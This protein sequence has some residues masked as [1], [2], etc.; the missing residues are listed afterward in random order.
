MHFRLTPRTMTLDDVEVLQGQ[1][2][3]EFRKISQIWEPT[4]AK[5]MKIDPYCQRMNVNPY[6][7]GQRGNLLN[8]LFKIMFLAFF[9]AHFL[10]HTCTAVDCCHALTL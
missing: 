8:V 9:A 10:F 4:T 1:I 3:S 6:C 2:I 5:R 7:Q